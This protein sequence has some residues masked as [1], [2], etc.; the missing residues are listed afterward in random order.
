MKNQIKVKECKKKFDEI[1]TH[2]QK[3]A[4][5][6]GF[7]HRDFLVRLYPEEI[8]GLV[9]STGCFTKNSIPIYFDTNKCGISGDFYYGQLGMSASNPLSNV[10]LGVRG[11]QEDHKPMMKT[12]TF[13]HA[14][15]PNITACYH[16]DCAGR[17][18]APLSY[19]Q[20]RNS[21][22]P[23]VYYDA[24]DC[25]LSNILSPMIEGIDVIKAYAT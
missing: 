14:P 2:F 10:F 1:I 15:A 25:R 22:L 13:V 17:H 24:Y 23:G 12:D 11:G 8:S 19:S 7:A 18:T 9:D 5:K 20:M 3:E 21:I 6:Q 4:E 16:L